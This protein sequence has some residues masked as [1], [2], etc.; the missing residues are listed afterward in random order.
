MIT[1]D[2]ITPAQLRALLTDSDA[3][4]R[5]CATVALGSALPAF[6]V[7]ARQAC[8]DL[9]NERELDKAAAPPVSPTRGAA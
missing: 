9:L 3:G 8:A 7:A 1:A 4:A 2:N 5:V 6:A